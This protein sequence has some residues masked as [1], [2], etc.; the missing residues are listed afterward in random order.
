VVVLDSSAAVDYLLGG[1]LGRWVAARL[2]VDPNLHAP[3]MIDV[4]VLGVFRRLV[5]SGEIS[6][7]RARQGLRDLIDLRVVRY[8]HVPLL[9]RMWELRSNVSPRDAAFVA[10]AELLGATLVTTDRRL[11]RAQGLLAAV[12]T[13]P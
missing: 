13:P 4:E 12:L 5:R 8:P 2:L 3:H 7:T 6:E 1:D 11:A 9:S 10:L